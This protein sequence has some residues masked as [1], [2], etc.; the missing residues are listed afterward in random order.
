MK[1]TVNFSTTM[2]FTAEPSVKITGTFEQVLET[3]KRIA[4]RS[5]E[6]YTFS[7]IADGLVRHYSQDG[8]LIDYH[9][10]FA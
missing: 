6:T 4:A 2:G 9:T 10:N 5:H 1:A 8:R 7:I 3:A